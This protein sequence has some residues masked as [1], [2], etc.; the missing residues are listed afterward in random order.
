[1]CQRIPSVV[2]NIYGVCIFEWDQ[3]DY[4]QLV[5]AKRGEL[6]NAGVRDPFPCAIKK[7][8]KEEELAHHCRRRTRGT[9]EFA[10]LI[11]ATV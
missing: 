10:I 8:L 4:D 5:S 3:A 7:A 1:M 9:T 11:E 2:W 6:L